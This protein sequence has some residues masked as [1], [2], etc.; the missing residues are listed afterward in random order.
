MSLGLDVST[1]IHATVSSCNCRFRAGPVI[2]LGRDQVCPLPLG[3]DLR[4]IEAL[5]IT[6]RREPP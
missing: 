5:D 1:S 3:S 2:E 6:F 4:H